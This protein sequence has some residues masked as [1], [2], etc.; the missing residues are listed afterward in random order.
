[1]LIPV[2]K[3]F[4]TQYLIMVTKNTDGSFISQNLMAVRFVPL[5]RK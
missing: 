4:G 5:V 1:M 3:R 2:G